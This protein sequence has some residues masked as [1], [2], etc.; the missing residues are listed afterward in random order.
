MTSPYEKAA[1]W[2]ADWA[3]NVNCL[4]LALTCFGE[5]PEIAPAQAQIERNPCVPSAAVASGC[6]SL[7]S[8]TNARAESKSTPHWS[9]PLPRSATRL[10]PSIR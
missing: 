8:Y 2:G 6:L 7:N 5:A 10:A 9:K 3:S 1:S 4:A